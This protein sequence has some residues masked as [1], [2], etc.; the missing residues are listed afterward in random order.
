MSS[1]FTSSS[2][3]ICVH[4]WLIPLSFAQRQHHR[5]LLVSALDADA[6]T[7][8]VAD[9][10]E[11]R[12]EVAQAADAVAA[13]REDHVAGLQARAAGGAVTLDFG[14]EHAGVGVQVL[15]L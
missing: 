9:V 3:S 15:L 6:Q 13:H 7:A 14:D 5:A 2:V 8:A 12:G 4:L 10:L 1:C 11:E